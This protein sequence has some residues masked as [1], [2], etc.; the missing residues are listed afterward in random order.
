[1]K[2]NKHFLSYLSH[3]FL[4]WEIFPPNVVEIIKT[5]FAFSNFSFRKSYRLWD[6]VKKI[7]QSG[8]D[9]RW[10]Y[11]ACELYAGY[12]RLQTHTLRLGNTHCL[13]TATMVARMCLSVTIYVQSLSCLKSLRPNVGKRA[14]NSGPPAVS[15][16]STV[17]S[18]YRFLLI[19]N[20]LTVQSIQN[21]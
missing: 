2:T 8:A 5:Y 4:E 19:R 15:Q 7:L 14:E 11:G 6:N 10:Q 13:S 21:Y 16:I 1:M 17:Y 18:V 9:H 12:L 20:K 3:F